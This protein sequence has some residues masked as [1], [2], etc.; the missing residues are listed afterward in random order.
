LTLVDLR[1][2]IKLNC[3]FGVLVLVGSTRNPSKRMIR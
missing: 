2:L 3:K 1:G